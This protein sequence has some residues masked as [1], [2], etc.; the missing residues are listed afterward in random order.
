MSRDRHLIRGI[1]GGMAAG[2]G[3]VTAMKS[4]TP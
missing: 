2:L 4:I 1:V 3:S